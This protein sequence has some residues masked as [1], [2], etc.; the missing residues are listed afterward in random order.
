MNL[1]NITSRFF[2]FIGYLSLA[3]AGDEFTL[4]SVTFGS[5]IIFDE[6]SLLTDFFFAFILIVLKSFANSIKRS[7]FT[8]FYYALTLI[9]FGRCTVSIERSLLTDFFFASISNNWFRLFCI[10]FRFYLKFQFFKGLNVINTHFVNLIQIFLKPFLGLRFFHN[11]LKLPLIC[12]WFRTLVFLFTTIQ[13]GII[14]HVVPRYSN[15][16]VILQTFAYKFNTFFWKINHFWN[17]VCTN[18]FWNFLFLL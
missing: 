6:R 16:V 4:I 3:H 11:L 2:D 1:F 10:G 8:E 7:R 18:I 13:V 5:F 17:I 9:V 12:I 14:H 15:I